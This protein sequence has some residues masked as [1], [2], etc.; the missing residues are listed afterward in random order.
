VSSVAVYGKPCRKPMP[1]HA[2]QQPS[3][4]YECTKQRGERA[5]LD[6]QRE[7]FEVSVARPTL[8]YGPRSTYGQAMMIAAA[9]QAA[10]LGAR[11]VPLIEGG[12]LGHHVH[13]EDVARAVE[14][15]CFH[16]DAPG[17][18]FN[19]ADDQPLPFGDSLLSIAK[20]LGL[21]GLSLQR[22]GTVLPRP[23]WRVIGALSRRLP[24]GV[25][26]K[27]NRQ[28]ERGHRALRK[29]GIEARLLPHFDRGWLQYLSG[30]Y[31][32]DTTRLRE[33]GFS[34]KHGDFRRSIGSVIDWYRQHGWIA[35]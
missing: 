21:K 14:L 25:L 7:G 29:R 10:A 20:V 31:V 18:C 11:R 34:P 33:L 22:L 2:P 3:S 27:L 35:R 16:P 15:L 23:L 4:A 24:S 1:E 30:D 6:E 32:F 13:V 28:L 5:V 12:P 19:I 17:R 8:V 9:A 26:D